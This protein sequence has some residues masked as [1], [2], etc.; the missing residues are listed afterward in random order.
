MNAEKLMLQ[1]FPFRG[2]LDKH[3]RTYCGSDQKLLTLMTL[4]KYMNW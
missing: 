1:C 4:R 3:A 2:L